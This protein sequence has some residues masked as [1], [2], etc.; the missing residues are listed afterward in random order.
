MK[1]R[2]E[3]FGESS[4]KTV[5]DN[6]FSIIRKTSSSDI[7]SIQKKELSAYQDPAV[8]LFPFQSVNQCFKAVKENSVL[9]SVD[10]PIVQTTKIKCTGVTTNILIPQKSEAEKRKEK[11]DERRRK[12]YEKLEKD[13]EMKDLE[14]NMR[15]SDDLKNNEKFMILFNFLN[16]D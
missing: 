7:S 10:I 8:R 6:F 4:E 1:R 5:L 11:L 13:K 15:L 14:S 12:Y 2:S 3:S 9:H 16:K